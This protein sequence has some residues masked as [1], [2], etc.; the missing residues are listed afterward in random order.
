MYVYKFRAKNLTI[1]SQF[2]LY[3]SVN[4]QHLVQVPPPLE[5]A[6]QTRENPLVGVVAGSI[7]LDKVVVVS[8]YNYSK[9]SAT[10]AAS[11]VATFDVELFEFLTIFCRF[12]SL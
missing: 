4:S 10:V 11:A 3:K 1:I 7:I 8:S 2:C 9:S 12:S 6:L 5:R